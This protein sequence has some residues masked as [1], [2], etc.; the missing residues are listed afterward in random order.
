M[1]K[2][3]PTKTKH[4][5]TWNKQN[6]PRRPESETVIWKLADE[7]EFLAK[8]LIGINVVTIFL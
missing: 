4:T 5:E 1:L 6:W 8:R 2:L 3:E 7:Y